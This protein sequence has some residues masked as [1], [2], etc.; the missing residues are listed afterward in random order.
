[1]AGHSKWANIKHR[2]ARQDE[3][4]G[5]VWSKCSRAIIVAAR[6][7]GGDLDT[8][9]TLRYAVD[10]A[11]AANMPKDTID[12][13]IKKGSGELGGENYE[14]ATYE[15]YGPNGVAIFIDC[16]TDNRNRTAGEVRTAFAKHG[17]NLGTDGSVAYIFARKGLFTVPADKFDEDTIMEAALEAGADDVTLDG[18]SWQILTEPADFQQVRGNLETA[19]V[20]FEVAEL[21][22][23]PNNTVTCEGGDAKKVMNLID[24]LEDNDDVQKVYTNVEISDE[25][26]AAME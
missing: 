6:A 11:K 3:K 1:M 8:N 10:E 7:G 22:M 9:L 5:K 18:D 20:E 24:T 2:K 17:G 26:L 19:G 25:T 13:A 21:T 12:K 4:K 15:G 16:L 14:Q 23:L